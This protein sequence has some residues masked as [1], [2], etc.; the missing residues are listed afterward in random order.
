[1]S[2]NQGP[3]SGKPPEDPPASNK[4]VRAPSLSEWAVLSAA[5][6]QKFL[7]AALA[8]HSDPSEAM[9]EGRPH[10]RAKNAALDELSLH[11]GSTGR[12][13]Y[14]ADEMAVVYPA[15]ESFV[16]DILAVLDVAQDPEQD[17]RTAWV[18]ADEGKGPDLIIEVLD[19]GNRHKDLGQNVDR[20]ASLGISEYFVYNRLKERLH[21]FRLPSPTAGRYQ[22]LSPRLGR[23]R[24]QVLGLDLALVGGRLRFFSGFSALIG[25]AEL[26]GQL[27]SMMDRA[28]TRIA[29]LEARLMQ[30][31]TEREQAVVDR[32]QA[33]ADREQALAGMRQVVLVL[34]EVL[35][36]GIS[37]TQRAAVERLDVGSAGSLAA[38]LRAH[39]AWPADFPPPENP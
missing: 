16:P 11:F 31:E 39:R 6:K 30:V 35:G 1:M 17:R 10:K 32:E 28:D 19:Q 33:V 14:L 27:S 5:Q 13:I 34:C 3:I 29:A 2:G 20:Y 37:P 21:G 36:L 22:E 12:S 4:G 7:D 26:I 15:Q 8:A 38:H 9:A 18:V 25:S 24:S 23:V